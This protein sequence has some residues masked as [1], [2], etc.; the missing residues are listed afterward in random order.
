MNLTLSLS[1]S[2]ANQLVPKN[3]FPFFLTSIVM[4]VAATPKVWI[5]WNGC[6]VYMIYKQETRFLQFRY[7]L[8]SSFLWRNTLVLSA[9]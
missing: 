7:F 5:L 1:S 6:Y 3:Q 2:R 9:S 8:A 4:I